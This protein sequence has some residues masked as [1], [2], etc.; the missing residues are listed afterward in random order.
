MFEF[1]TCDGWLLVQ[2]IKCKTWRPD[3]NSL[4]GCDKGKDREY[5]FYYNGMWWYMVGK[6]K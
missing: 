2:K 5:R 1:I 4:A 6:R 3:D